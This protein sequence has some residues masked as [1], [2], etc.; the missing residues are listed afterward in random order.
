M[1]STSAPPGGDRLVTTVFVARDRATGHVHGTY[2]HSSLERAQSEEHKRTLD[3]WTAEMQERVGPGTDLD[4]TIH[5]AA[6]LDADWS[7]H[8]QQ[9]G[10]PAG[11]R[12]TE[13]SA[14]SRP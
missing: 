9:V 7:A 12:L 13:S 1:I 10:K 14:I 5:S 6:A 3:R 4:V 11:R 8:A 2:T